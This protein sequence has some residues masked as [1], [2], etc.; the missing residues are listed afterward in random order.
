MN[1]VLK[2]G[3]V[4]SNQIKSNRIYGGKFLHLFG[5]NKNI[6]VSF[7]HPYI[8]ISLKKFLSALP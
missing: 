4:D 5:N 8:C 6:C 7:V 2:N 3:G 1:I